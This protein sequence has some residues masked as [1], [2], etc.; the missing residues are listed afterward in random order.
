MDLISD[1]AGDCL[2]KAEE[3]ESGIGEEGWCSLGV[4]QA[5]LCLDLTLP[6]GQSFRWR[7]TGPSQYTG[8]INTHLVSLR[9]ISNNVEFLHHASSATAS[10]SDVEKE[11]R[12]YL[13][14]DTSLVELYA[15]F[16]AA[17]ARF[18][19]VAPF[20]AGAR[21]L[22]QP[23]LE[24]VFQ[25]ICSSNNHIQRITTMVDYLSSQGLFLGSVN[26]FRF[27][28]FPTLDQLSPL[29]EAELRETGF[30]YR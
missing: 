3:V 9:Q 26:G 28:Q 1:V 20:I 8:V 21:L 14:L 18:A 27:H 24:C 5:E 17:D 19:A 7:K 22:R 12:E 25:F 4:G 6:T 29:S 23:P 13:N 15:K 2:V 16:T 11:I 10:L 30:G